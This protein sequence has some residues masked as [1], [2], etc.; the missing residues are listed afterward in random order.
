MAQ[1]PVV[2]AVEADHAVGDRGLTRQDHAPRGNAGRRLAEGR[3]EPGAVAGQVVQV[4]GAKDRV[5]GDAEGIA[6]LLIGSNQENV[7]TTLCHDSQPLIRL[8]AGCNCSGRSSG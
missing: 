5:T 1:V 2:A 3:A 4:G 7:G 6:A 8:V